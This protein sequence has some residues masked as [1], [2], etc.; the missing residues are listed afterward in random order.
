MWTK[1]RG[2]ILFVFFFFCWMGTMSS[3]YETAS[4]IIFALAV[5]CPAFGYGLSLL[6]EIRDSL[7]AKDS[8]SA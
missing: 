6:E 1:I 5:A 7:K 2:Y 3:G 4:A 8:R